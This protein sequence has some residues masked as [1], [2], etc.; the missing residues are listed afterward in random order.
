MKILIMKIKSHLKIKI[1]KLKINPLM[2]RLL[3]KKVY[4]NLKKMAL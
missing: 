1:K 4:N 2:M 3:N